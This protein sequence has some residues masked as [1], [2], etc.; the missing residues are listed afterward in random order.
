MTTRA[1]TSWWAEPALQRNPSAFY[2]EVRRREP[3][4]VESKIGREHWPLFA[5]D[6]KTPRQPRGAGRS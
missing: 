6:V 5:P 1:S 3:V 4:I 2:A